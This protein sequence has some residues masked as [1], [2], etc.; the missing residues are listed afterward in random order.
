MAAISTIQ[1]LRSNIQRLAAQRYLYS[2][3]KRLSAIQA[4]LAVVT[5]A[6]ALWAEAQPWAALAG[7][8]VPLLDIGWL[9]PWQGRCR[10]AAANMQEDF[11]CNVLSLPWNEVLAG[12]RPAAEEIYEA[13]KKARLPEA[14][15]DNWYPTIIDSLPLHQSRVICQRTN[16]WWD[17]KLRC[18]Y[19]IKI[20]IALNL[21]FVVALFLGLLTEMPLQ[22][23][24]LAVAAPLS[25]TFLWGIREAWRQKEAAAALDRLKDLGDSLWEEVVQGEVME[26]EATSRSRELQNAILLCRRTNPFVFDWIYW[27][28]RR[29]Y[30]E[31]MNVGAENMVAQVNTASGTL[32]PKTSPV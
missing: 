3:A 15:L 28:S 19:K 7:I 11:D 31:Q 21:I 9:D 17:S 16:W 27:R 18:R 14:P 22:K 12:R 2:W 20:L 13:A 8:L 5:P 26:P 6:A 23:F 1:N 4:W 10:E 32:P 25:P 30:E 29:D 24:V